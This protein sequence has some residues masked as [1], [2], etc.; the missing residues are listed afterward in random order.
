MQNRN[1][2]QIRNKNQIPD[3]SKT[4][5]MSEEEFI[6]KLSTL[7]GVIQ[8][9]GGIM[10][11]AASFMALQKFQRDIILD[12]EEEGIGLSGDDDRISELEK[13]IQFLMREIEVLKGQNTKN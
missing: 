13:Q 6:A 7:G 8:T 3:T 2:N 10:S 9:V 5:A 12:E 4:S 11:T 1:Q